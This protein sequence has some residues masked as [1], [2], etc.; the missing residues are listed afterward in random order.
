MAMRGLIVRAL[1]AAGAAVA[2]LIPAAAA[3]AAPKPVLGWQFGHP[4]MITAYDFGMFIPGS[5]SQ[6]VFE[7]VNLSD[8]ASSALTIT[9]TGSAVFSKGDL[10]TCTGTSL[11]P[12]GS[13]FVRIDVFPPS[14]P[15]QTY[16]GI[17]TARPASQDRPA[18]SLTLQAET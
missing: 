1:V 16:S 5:S 7:V 11:P 4:P 12:G 15:G 2:L 3:S 13:C 6:T 14:T 8:S 18:A 17:A 9:V 10:D